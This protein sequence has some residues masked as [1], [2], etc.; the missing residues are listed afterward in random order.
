MPPERRTF[1]SPPR[2]PLTASL[3]NTSPSTSHNAQPSSSSK[4]QTP[5][6]LPNIPDSYISSYLSNRQ[7]KALMLNKAHKRKVP[8][9]EDRY[10]YLSKIGDALQKQQQHQQ[11]HQQQYSHQEEPQEPQQMPIPIPQFQ[12]IE[13][14]VEKNNSSFARQ[15]SCTQSIP[16][17]LPIPSFPTSTTIPGAWLDQYSSSSSSPLSSPSTTITTPST[18]QQDSRSS[19]PR[20]PHRY[21]FDQ[22][23]GNENEATVR[24]SLRALHNSIK[25]S[26]LPPWVAKQNL[27]RMRQRIQRRRA[28]TRET[29]LVDLH[30]G[31]KS[32]ETEVHRKVE[33][34]LSR[35]KEVP[36]SKYAFAIT[37]SFLSQIPSIS[38]TL[39]PTSQISSPETKLNLMDKVAEGDEGKRSDRSPHVKL[40]P[41]A[42]E[43]GSGNPHPHHDPEMVSSINE[44]CVSLS[45]IGASEVLSAS[46][47]TSYTTACSQ[48]LNAALPSFIPSMVAPLVCVFNYPVPLS[49]SSSSSSSSTGYSSST[50]MSE[51]QCQQSNRELSFPWGVPGRSPYN[52]IKPSQDIQ[53]QKQSSRIP[54]SGIVMLNSKSWTQSEREALY[55]AATRLRL[56]GQWS[57]I[58]EMMCLQRTDQEIEAEY[59]RLYGHRC[60]DTNTEDESMG[61]SMDEDADDEAEEGSSEVFMKFGGQRRQHSYEVTRLRANSDEKKPI[62]LYKKDILI[63]KR[64][65]LEEIPSSL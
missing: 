13:S 48:V 1:A 8:T 40:E 45:R 12:S 57:K 34:V 44:N 36:A 9:P 37:N 32:V 14:S 30:Q 17:P 51:T 39:S 38:N 55:L 35:L 54:S 25:D 43:I 41:I 31:V 50:A 16:A 63:D 20:R 33:M 5:K 28:R 62:R 42:Q 3:P 53:N 4:S 46:M 15:N 2:S 47:R 49:S 24:L 56:D 23:S 64:F 27:E 29:I 11:Q 58:R 22:A 19:S 6:S 52:S 21:R 7:A 18:P 26:S 60:T 10:Q 65:K 59:N 61:D